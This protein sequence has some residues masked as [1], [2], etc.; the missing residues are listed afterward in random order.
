MKELKMLQA[1]IGKV[2]IGKES[3]PAI[4]FERKY[5]LSKGLHKSFD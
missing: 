1:E 4:R 3:L 2:I 5:M